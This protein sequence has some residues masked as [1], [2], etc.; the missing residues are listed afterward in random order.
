MAP[1]QTLLGA[2]RQI[3]GQALVWIVHVDPVPLPLIQDV[4]ADTEK[5]HSGPS[6]ERVE[7]Q[8]Q[9]PTNTVIRYPIVEEILCSPY[10]P[11]ETQVTEVGL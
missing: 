2:E 7:S 10:R 9:Y 3:V 6:T 5:K 1:K 11:L 8:A 4:A